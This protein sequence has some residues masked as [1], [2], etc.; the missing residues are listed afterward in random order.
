MA[1]NSVFCYSCNTYMPAV[2][3]GGN[4]AKMTK[5]ASSIHIRCQVIQRSFIDRGCT[6]G[7]RTTRRLSRPGFI[8]GKASSRAS[9]ANLSKDALR[10]VWKASWVPDKT[11]YVLPTLTRDGMVRLIMYRTHRFTS[12]LVDRCDVARGRVQQDTDN[13]HWDNNRIHGRVVPV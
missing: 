12:Q 2:D 5:T 3:L 8:D 9:C 1:P 7:Q 4:P 6:R 13:G 10:R 11:G